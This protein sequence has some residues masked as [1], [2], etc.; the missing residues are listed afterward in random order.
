MDEDAIDRLIAE[1]TYSI[2][3]AI[4]TFGVIVLLVLNTQFDLLNERFNL[5]PGV[6][7]ISNFAVPAFVSFLCGLFLIL[8]RRGRKTTLWGLILVVA[9]AESMLFG[10]CS[11]L[12]LR[13]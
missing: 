4:V 10:D 7:G 12:V 8:F 3:I 2:P 6:R 11:S 9:R 1:K 5:N 13:R